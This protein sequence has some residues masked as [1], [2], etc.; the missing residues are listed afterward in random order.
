MSTIEITT[1]STTEENEIKEK[2][3]KV[4]GCLGKGSYGTVYK[5]TDANENT[6][7]IKAVEFKKMYHNTTRYCCSTT[8]EFTVSKILSTEH[9][10]R[11]SE[12]IGVVKVLDVFE[13]GKRYYV[14]MECLSGETIEDFI[15]SNHSLSSLSSQDEETVVMDI[16]HQVIAGLAFLGK[17]GIAHRD[18]KPDN[19]FLCGSASGVIAKIIDVGLGRVSVERPYVDMWGRRECMR[20]NVGTPLYASP[21][22]EGCSGYTKRC[23]LWGAGMT[24]YYL[25]TGKD[26]VE[27]DPKTYRSKKRE[28]WNACGKEGFR[29]KHVSSD[30]I[31][32]LLR[33][34]LSREGPTAE[35][36]LEEYWPDHSCA[37]YSF[38]PCPLPSTRKE[39]LEDRLI[40][41]SLAEEGH[42][43]FSDK[44]QSYKGL[45]VAPLG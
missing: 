6:Y 26:L 38:S 7:A 31:N 30:R 40:D 9:A 34:M 11:S 32:D 43:L 25:A 4:L 24:L 14:V 29:F 5:A 13:T 17:L 42:S 18:I 3:Y 36:I 22:V 16:A 45:S 1:I 19:I 8:D 44:M 10:N 21:E 15:Q 23:D 2:G 20:S 35:K 27:P 37:R 28:V 12:Y 41:V 33:K 39:V